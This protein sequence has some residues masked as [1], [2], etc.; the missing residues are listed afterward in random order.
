MNL[1]PIVGYLLLFSLDKRLGWDFA[2]CFGLGEGYSR[3]VKVPP[4]LL[5]AL[6]GPLQVH[7]G[8]LGEPDCHGLLGRDVQ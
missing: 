7:Q 2:R 4:V 3:L 6:G 5:E 8:L 1:E